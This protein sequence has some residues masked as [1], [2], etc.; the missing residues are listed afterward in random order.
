M[1]NDLAVVNPKYKKIFTE[2]IKAKVFHT[3]PESAITFL[4]NE[5]K[6]IQSW[7]ESSSVRKAIE[8]FKD[9]HVKDDLISDNIFQ[10]LNKEKKLLN[11]F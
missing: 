9:H 8:L 2:L 11:E 7:W 5:G 1:T 6:N 10:L 3:T 4:N